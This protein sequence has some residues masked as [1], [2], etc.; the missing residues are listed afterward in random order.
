MKGAASERQKTHLRDAQQTAYC[1]WGRTHGGHD[2][3]W[4][5]RL[6]LPDQARHM[7]EL[8]MDWRRLSTAGFIR[9]TSDGFLPSGASLLSL[10][11]G[12]SMEWARA[13]IRSSRLKAV[14][15]ATERV[16]Q[17]PVLVLSPSVGEL[18]PLCHYDY[19]MLLIPRSK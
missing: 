18:L 15:E 16:H 4:L 13:W 11:M 1:K 10:Q 5:T 8:W 6:T 12:S 7:G 19:M 3:G 14:A 9:Q 2:R 17:R